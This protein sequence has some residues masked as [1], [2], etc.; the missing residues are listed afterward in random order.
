MVDLGLI[1][2][3][4]G[5]LDPTFAIQVIPRVRRILRLHHQVDIDLNSMEIVL[6]LLQRIEEL[7]S[8]LARL[9]MT[10]RNSDT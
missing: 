8:I 2:A 1:S 5:E 7:E 6:D 10:G 3:V 4:G 9:T